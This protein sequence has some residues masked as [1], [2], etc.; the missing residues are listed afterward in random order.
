MCYR[1]KQI[2]QPVYE[3]RRLFVGIS[4]VRQLDAKNPATFASRRPQPVS[5]AARS[6]LGAAAPLLSSPAR[7]RPY[8]PTRRGADDAARPVTR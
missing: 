6:S 4:S 5:Q 1:V 2:V 8:V 3:A 7:R